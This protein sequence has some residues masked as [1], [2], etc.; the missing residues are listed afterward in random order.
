MGTG[1][2]FR[3]SDK[4]F[5]EVA[6][7]C[8]IA[9]HAVKRLLGSLIVPL[10]DVEGQADQQSTVVELG[11][12]LAAAQDDLGSVEY[13]SPMIVSLLQEYRRVC[14]AV[15]RQLIRADVSPLKIRSVLTRAQVVH[16]RRTVGRLRAQLVRAL[17]ASASKQGA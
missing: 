9:D 14:P 5:R 2:T 11:F 13:Q 10:T 8:D 4:L 3:A 17:K 1:K 6:L 12:C 7:G 16:A 15:F